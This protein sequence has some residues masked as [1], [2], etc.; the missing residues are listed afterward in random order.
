ME[1]LAGV[2]VCQVSAAGGHSMAFTE[3]RRLW[4]F[5]CGDFGRLGH[6]DEE[7]LLVPK[8]VDRVVVCGT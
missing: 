5:G 6:G 2:R 7:D 4:S 8:L 3:G 1:R